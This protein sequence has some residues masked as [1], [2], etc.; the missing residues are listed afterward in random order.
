MFRPYILGRLKEDPH[1]GRLDH[2]NIVIGIT[3]GDNLVV[4]AFECLDG[5]AFAVRLAQDI[6]ADGALAVYLQGVA[7]Q[8]RPVEFLHERAGKFNKRI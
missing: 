1:V 3:H 4:E 8:G 7:E 2:G 5:L 6:P